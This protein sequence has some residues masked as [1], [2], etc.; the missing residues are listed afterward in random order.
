MDTFELLLAQTKSTSEQLMMIPHDIKS[1]LLIHLANEIIDNQHVVLE[2]N[3][4][5]LSNLN[6]DDPKY[7]RLLLTQQRLQDIAIGLNKIALYPSP[8]WKTLEEFTLK[9]G[10]FV[11]RKSVPL[12]VIAMIYESRPN[13]TIE[14][15][16][17]CWMSSNA[18][19]LKGGSEAQLTNEVLIKI[20]HK[21]LNQFN[22]SIS[23]VL[24]LPNDRELVKRLLTA[25]KYVDVIIPRGS[26]ALIDFVKKNS[27]IPIIETGAGVVHLYFDKSGDTQIGKDI[28]TNA[29][30]RRV[31]VCNALDCL[32]IH[33]DCLQDLPFLVSDLYPHNVQLFADS[34]SYQTLELFY[35]GEL[36]SP[37]SEADYGTEF[38]D[39]KLAIK[40]VDSFNDAIMHIQQYSSKHSEAIVAEEKAIIDQFFCLVDS[41]V[42]YANASTAFTDGGEFG[43]GGEI[44]IS[45]QKLHVR[46]PFSMQHL[47]SSKWII[48]GKGQ[49]RS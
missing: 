4:A 26:Q 42:V 3:K 11:Q 49:V 45:T 27:L 35:P 28:I 34:L 14:A 32:I 20:I 29:K 22:L 5:D 39:Y 43:M 25:D 15:F 8:V 31:S 7:D 6:S 37:V 1:K 19:I 38:L 17:L 36:L 18:C 13:V 48:Q 12:G 16:A 2:S 47:V 46:G 24:L 10:L 41:A 9:N 30:T 21:V 44:G 33:Q 40:T 23:C